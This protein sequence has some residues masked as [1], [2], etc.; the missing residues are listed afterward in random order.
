MG[1]VSKLVS[2]ISFIPIFWHILSPNDI[3]LWAST[4]CTKRYSCH[5]IV[6]WHLH[7]SHVTSRS[8]LWNG[9]QNII[10]MQWPSVI[11]WLTGSLVWWRLIHE[12]LHFTE[13]WAALNAIYPVSGCG[14]V[15]PTHDGQ[16][17]TVWMTL[18]D[19]NY[20]CQ[21]QGV[22]HRTQ[23]HTHTHHLYYTHTHTH[24]YSIC[25]HSTHSLTHN[26]HK[27]LHHMLHF[28]K[29][30]IKS[31]DHWMNYISFNKHKS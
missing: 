23:T 30:Y 11:M 31:L 12:S 16:A 6:T 19:D 26:L 14:C 15:H 9:I 20:D 18:K 3:I 27:S 21:R 4:A 2:L 25:T 22:V 5:V 13:S 8:T 1:W 24:T 7:C 28:K 17:E 10:L 29:M